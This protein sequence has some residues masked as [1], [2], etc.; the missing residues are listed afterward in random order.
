MKK[1]GPLLKLVSRIV[2]HP[3]YSL[4]LG[5]V[6]M[7][8]G[9]LEGVETVIEDFF[10]INVEGQ[11]GIIIFGFGAVLKSLSDI[12]EGSE[13]ILVTEEV[14]MALNQRDGKGSSNTD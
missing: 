2:H 11:H 14:S 4:V 7:F 3:R 12:L 8:C 1:K 9:I 6:L 5:L 13:E 10:E